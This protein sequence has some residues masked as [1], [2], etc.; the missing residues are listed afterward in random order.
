MFRS[1]KT[2]T[3]NITINENINLFYVK[4]HEKPRFTNTSLIK[5]L[6]NYKEVRLLMCWQER[7]RFS[8][9]DGMMFIF[10]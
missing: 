1:P 6:I 9:I 8:Q 2:L 10:E 3:Q 7:N 4:I 5:G